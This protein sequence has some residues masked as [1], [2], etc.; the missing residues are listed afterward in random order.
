MTQ[1][2]ELVTALHG[3][4]GTAK[5]SKQLAESIAAYLIDTRQTKDAGPLLRELESIRLAKD[6]TLE[7]R[8]TSARP[9]SQAT[10]DSIRALFKVKNIIIHEEHD[11][12]ILGGVKVR[13]HDQQLDTSV[14]TRLQ[15]LKA[16]V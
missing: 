11:P 10:R 9:L 3:L 5:D 14:R 13:A 2:K 8:V 7:V 6:D 15:R 12:S 16:G 1:R 4:I